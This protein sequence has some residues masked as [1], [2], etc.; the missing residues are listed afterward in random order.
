MEGGKK[1]SFEF[2]GLVILL[3][4]D[5]WSIFLIMYGNKIFNRLLLDLKSV[6]QRRFFE[7]VIVVSDYNKVLEFKF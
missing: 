2:L 7:A 1:N 6:N 5:Y 4:A 3:I